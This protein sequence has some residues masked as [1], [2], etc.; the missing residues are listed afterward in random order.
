MWN[1]A[2]V[3]GMRSRRQRS[4]PKLIAW[5]CFC[6]KS[7]V[8][9]CA[10]L[11]WQLQV[12]GHLKGVC[13]GHPSVAHYMHLIVQFTAFGKWNHIPDGRGN[14]AQALTRKFWINSDSYNRFL[15][16]VLHFGGS[17][18]YFSIKKKPKIG[19]YQC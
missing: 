13:A 16:M 9:N 2:Y 7:F 11:I 6:R 1:G 15:W 12:Q 4:P 14:A 18:W 17:L 19:E 5:G 3:S 10:K 8:Q